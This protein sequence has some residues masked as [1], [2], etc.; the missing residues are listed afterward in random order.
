[1]TRHFTLMGLLLGTLLILSSG[2]HHFL[3]RRGGAHR[4]GVYVGVVGDPEIVAAGSHGIYWAHH[5][6]KD[7]FWY[8]GYWYWCD[9]PY[10]YQS[11][12]WGGG[13][14][15]VSRPPQVF[16]NLP[17]GHPRHSVVFRH[18]RHVEYRT[19]HRKHYPR[20]TRARSRVDFKSSRLPRKPKRHFKGPSGKPKR[21]LRGK[22]PERA[23]K[24]RESPRKPK[25][26]GKA[27]SRRGGG[28]KANPRKGASPKRKTEKKKAPP[29]KK[30]GKPDKKKR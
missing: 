15:H 4:G 7:I 27:E 3:L 11:S 21:D 24:G 26:A 23:N 30:R 1:M 8:G 28:A 29:S 18:P 20:Y 14:A 25:G 12:R 6:E 10:W 17:F 22:G 16:L 13:W 5:L 2:C 9:G 19:Y